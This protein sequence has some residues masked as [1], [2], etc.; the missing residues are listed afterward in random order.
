MFICV[1]C[2]AK[3][4]LTAFEHCLP[5]LATDRK[6]A[7]DQFRALHTAERDN[8]TPR[9]TEIA[10][11]VSWRND[12]RPRAG[13]G[14]VRRGMNI[15]RARRFMRQRPSQSACHAGATLRARTACNSLK[16]PTVYHLQRAIRSPVVPSPH[17]AVLKALPSPC[18]PTR[19]MRGA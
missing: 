14:L 2:A 8:S 7:G 4:H 15:A 16:I 19:C 9:G 12:L 18:R 13:C 11:S 17:P 5:V 6:G 1:I 3:R 10:P